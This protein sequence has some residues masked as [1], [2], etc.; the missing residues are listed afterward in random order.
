[1]FTDISDLPAAEALFEI[2]V[3]VPE[4]GRSST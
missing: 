3:D 1:M 2:F 4:T